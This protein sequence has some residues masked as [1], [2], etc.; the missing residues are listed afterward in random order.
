MTENIV[1]YFNLKSQ[2]SCINLRLSNSYGEPYSENNDCWNLVVN[3]LCFNAFKYGKIEIE[4]KLKK[5]K[6]LYTL[7]RY[8][9][10][11]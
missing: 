11:C 10:R 3:N 7:P 9:Q 5:Y 1:N 4:I 6:K 8:I 2:I